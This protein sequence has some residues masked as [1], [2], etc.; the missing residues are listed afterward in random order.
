[1]PEVKQLFSILVNKI[2]YEAE[3]QQR[4]S[5]SNITVQQNE[6]NFLSV[7]GPKSEHIQ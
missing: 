5:S 2:I 6:I 4:I 7:Y 3:W 1:M